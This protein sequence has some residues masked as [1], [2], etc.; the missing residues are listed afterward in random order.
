MQT[1]TN[2]GNE[3]CCTRLYLQYNLSR[4]SSYKYGIMNFVLCYAINIGFDLILKAL[5]FTEQKSFFN[6]KISGSHTHLCLGHFP[7][8]KHEHY[9]PYQDSYQGRALAFVLTIHESRVR[10]PLDSLGCKLD[11]QVKFSITG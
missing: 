1:T 10:F 6:A 8:M 11:F 2:V 7:I 3:S 4:C 9:V 5:V